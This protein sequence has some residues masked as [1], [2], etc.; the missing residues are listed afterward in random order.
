MKTRWVFVI[1]FQFFLMV[2]FVSGQH[3]VNPGEIRVDSTFYHIGVLWS[4]SGDTNLDSNLKIE[5]RSSRGG[6]WKPG[7]VA[8]R[9]H[10]KIEVEG[11]ELGVNYWAGSAMFLK[12]GSEY[13]LKLTLTDPDGGGAARTIK[14]ATKKEQQ[15]SP[16]GTKYYVKPGNGGGTGTSADPFKGL[17]TAASRAKPGDIFHI[18][19]GNYK[20]FTIKVS[21]KQGAPI[22]FKGPDDKTAVVDGK[23]TSEAIIT[24]GDYERTYGY[25]IIEN[26]TIKNG[27]WG[28]DAQNT[29]HITFRN[30]VVTNVGWGYTNRRE[31]GLE[32]DQTISDNVFVGLTKW[33]ASEVPDERGINIIG[34]NNIVCRNKI[35]YFGDGI[36]TDSDPYKVSY[37][38][39]IY[40]NDISY[41]VGDLIEVDGTVA[42]T[43]VW[44]N[45]LYNG[46]MGVS[47]APVMGGPC[48]V[49]RNELFNIEDRDGDF[50]A[51]KMGRDPSGLVIVHNTAVKLGRGIT[52]P[53]GWQNTCFRNNVLL[54]THYVFEL[55]ELN[56]ASMMDDWDFNAYASSRPSGEP[57]FK[58]KDVRYATLN[59]LQAGA[60]IE[61]HSVSIT[62][63]DLLNAGLPS[64][65]EDGVFPGKRDLTLK[66]GSG[67]INAGEVL[68]NINDPFVTDGSPDCGAFEYGK[69]KPG[70]GP[71]CKKEN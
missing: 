5:Y 48:Y 47:V 40:Y 24:I 53:S 33:P 14:A 22:V 17:Q 28:V 45:R 62:F 6:K 63:A 7:A 38:L 58:W 2:S 51:Y 4:I 57:W 61:S 11:E 68:P 25:I 67:A 55:Y 30:N 27:N 16:S 35:S 18:G 13:E 36:S 59:H 10:P 23:K 39:D 70:Y 56:R 37:S 19:P 32:H 21:G 31:D 12:P 46:R 15:P 9:A 65:Y 69:P 66:A 64:K 29:H 50:T 54:S 3:S 34:N 52:A 26:L 44:R 8:M 60:G 1:F 41:C 43:R 49:F 42:N 71:G 20:P